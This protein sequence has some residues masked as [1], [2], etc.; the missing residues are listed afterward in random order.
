MRRSL[1]YFPFNFIDYISTT[2]VI[3][4]VRYG[5]ERSEDENGCKRSYF[6]KLS[7]MSEL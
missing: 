6:E 7:E 5:L 1:F 2:E 3:E 4:L